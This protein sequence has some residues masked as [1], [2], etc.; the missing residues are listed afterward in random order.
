MPS[1]TQQRAQQIFLFALAVLIL[2]V[3]A[4]IVLG[5]R[6]YFPPNFAADFLHGRESYFWGAYSWAF[7]A[8]ILAGPL[9]LVFGLLLI[10]DRFRLRFPG[11][12]RTLGKLQVALVLLVLAPSGLW[13][14]RYAQLGP[15][16]GSGFAVLSLLT[17]LSVLGGWRTAVRRRFAEHRVWMWRCYLLLCSAVVLRLFGGLAT[18]MELGPVWTYPFAAWA[19]WLLPL[20]VYELIRVWQSPPRPYRAD[21]S[22]SSTLPSSPAIVTI[23]RR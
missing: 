19:S 23:A 10:A 16:A 17:A 13:M 20:A 15:V 7:Y 1:I 6:E 18:V 11:W 9:T 3:T 22:N 21:S 12:H 5:Y 2:K 4:S 14:A 8:H